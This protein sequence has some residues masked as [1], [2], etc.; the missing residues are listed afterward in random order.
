MSK[1][2]CITLL[3]PPCCLGLYQSRL[4]IKRSKGPYA[5]SCPSIASELTFGRT[6]AHAIVTNVTGKL[7]EDQLIGTLQK[8]KFSL[9]VDEST[10]RSTTKH[11]ALIVRTAVDFDVED[12]F[13]RLIPVVDGTATALHSA[14]TKYFVEKNIPY[15]ENMVGFAADKTNPMFGQH[16]SLST[17]FA[18]DIPNLSLMKCKCHSFHLCA[19]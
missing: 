19:S 1:V 6:K 3:L 15:K 4:Q 17:L 12:S 10:D 9:I 5:I 7:A 18:K 8:N 14:C 11:L 2:Q 13:L 16:H